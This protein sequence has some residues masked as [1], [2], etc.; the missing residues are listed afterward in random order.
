MKFIR[1]PARFLFLSS[2][3][4]T[5]L[6]AMGFES[7]FAQESKRL[8]ASRLTS[9]GFGATVVLLGIAITLIGGNTKQAG[10]YMIVSAGTF[11][12][13]F[14]LSSGNRGLGRG[15]EVL[16]IVAIL[17]EIMVFRGSILEIRSKE[18]AFEGSLSVL[19]RVSNGSEAQRVFSN[20]YSLPQHIA[21]INSLQLADGINPLQL[22]NYSNYM[23]VAVGYHEHSY[24]VTIPPFPDGNPSTPQD[25]S[26]IAEELGNLNIAYVLSDYPLHAASLDPIDMVED[27]YI[28]K[29]AQVKPRAWIETDGREGS[30]W[31]EVDSI[32]WKPNEVVIRATGPG[33]L[34]LSEMIYPGWILTV[35]DLQSDIQD[36]REIFRAVML[37]P[38]EHLVRFTYRPQRVYLGAVISILSIIALAWLWIKR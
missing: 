38:G 12:I 16:W 23:A 10:L 28:Y 3:G 17:F 7:I 21:G 36:Y 27:V 1:V 4:F 9:L 5:V 25:F 15:K 22:E 32:E 34:I 13:L 6:S 30:D 31:R 29:N 2:F 37:E 26:M 8:P 14:F 24:S 20:S 35:D 18:V 19:E 33:Q 11:L